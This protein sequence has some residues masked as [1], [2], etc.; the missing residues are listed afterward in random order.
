MSAALTGRADVVSG[1]KIGD[2]AEDF[3]AHGVT[4]ILSD[5]DGSYLDDWLA[6]VFGFGT[7]RYGTA[8][9]PV[10]AQ[11]SIGGSDEEAHPAI[12][13]IAA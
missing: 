5:K 6:A 12:S 11:S 7:L 3:T 10:V 2:R 8:M 9:V 1:P 13:K 4:G